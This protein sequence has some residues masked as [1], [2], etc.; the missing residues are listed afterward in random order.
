MSTKKT[1]RKMMAQLTGE[2][3]IDDNVAERMRG[4]INLAFREREEVNLSYESSVNLCGFGFDSADSSDIPPV[5]V[6]YAKNI[7][8]D[9]G[10][11]ESLDDAEAE[12]KLDFF[13][14]RPVGNKIFW[15]KTPFVSENNDHQREKKTYRVRARFSYI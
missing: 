2:K 11:C 3:N 5:K 13:T 7:D 9:S 4:M 1:T 6:T 10:E 12:F 15:R 8:V 14:Q